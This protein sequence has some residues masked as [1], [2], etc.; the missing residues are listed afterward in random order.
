MNRIS[1]ESAYSDIENEPYLK[2]Y[3]LDYRN[4]DESTNHYRNPHQ[5]SNDGHKLEARFSTAMV[6]ASRSNGF[7]GLS[8]EDYII[9]ILSELNLKI[10][11][12]SILTER[13]ANLL[14]PLMGPP[15]ADQ[16]PEDVRKLV[17][18]LADSERTK[19]GECIDFKVTWQQADTSFFLKKQC[20]VIRQITAE[21]KDHAR[22]IP[23]KVMKEILKR[24]PS[25]SQVHLIAC[26][27]LQQK[28]KLELPLNRSNTCCVRQLTDRGLEPITGI[29]SAKEES[30]TCLVI[31]FQLKPNQAQSEEKV[32]QSKN[33]TQSKKRVEQCKPTQTQSAK[34]SKRMPAKLRK[35]ERLKQRRTK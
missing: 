29:R 21:M 14:V 11:T 13:W 3:T 20:T 15:N 34:G 23:G 8:L 16:W 27:T 31:V 6:V 17:P 22:P 18:L 25:D 1:T 33:Q 4:E 19:N 9:Q 2:A 12:H 32:E 10:A 7:S 28:Y 26:N 35:S 5:S 30:A 24:I